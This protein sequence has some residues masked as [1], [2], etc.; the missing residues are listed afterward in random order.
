MINASFWEVQKA[1]FTHLSQNPN[2]KDM[3]ADRLYDTFGPNTHFP[4]VIIGL[5]RYQPWSSKTFKG[6]DHHFPIHIWS[7]YKGQK[8]VKE[9]AELI[10][11]ALTT[12]FPNLAHQHIV[13]LHIEQFHVQV[14]QE[15]QLMHGVLKIRI[16]SHGL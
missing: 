15:N 3:I 5:G 10:E 1:I 8:E 14:D 13:G 16:R 11:R 9:I 4:Y 2:L 12:N 7:S 6:A